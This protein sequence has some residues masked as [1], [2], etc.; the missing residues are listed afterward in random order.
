MHITAGTGGGALE[1]A[2][3]P[4][5][6][7]V[8]KAPAFTAFRA[9]H[10]G[11][12]KI[13]VQ[14]TQLAVEALCGPASPGNEDMHCGESEIFDEIVIPVGGASAEPPARHSSADSLFH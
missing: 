5:L 10:H 7:D 12:L 2:A 13:S 1:H 9:I 3:T 6:W 4:C 8:C 11:F 14:P